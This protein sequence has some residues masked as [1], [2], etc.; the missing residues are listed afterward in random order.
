MILNF[1]RGVFCLQKPIFFKT[2]PR[3][4]FFTVVFDYNTIVKVEHGMLMCM[5]IAQ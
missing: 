2:K 1:C 5:T 4:E 3:V